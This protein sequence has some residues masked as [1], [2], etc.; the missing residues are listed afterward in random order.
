M[1]SVAREGPN[2]R[3]RVAGRTR[4]PSESARG[5]A[6]SRGHIFG[7]ALAFRFARERPA[8]SRAW[9]TFR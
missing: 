9:V 1:L 3:R 7:S 8:P 4:L 5:R 6:F 2:G